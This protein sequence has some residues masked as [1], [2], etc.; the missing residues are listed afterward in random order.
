MQR[1]DFDPI[2]FLFGVVFLGL[3]V[4]FMTDQLAVLNHATWLWPVLLVLLGLAVLVGARG[5][6]GSRATRPALGSGSRIDPDLEDELLHSPMTTIDSERLEDSRSLFTLR[7]GSHPTEE[8]AA[9]PK[10]PEPKDPEPKEKA[11][12][13]AAEPKEA[14]TDVLP[15]ADADTEL[16]P[17]RDPRRE[18]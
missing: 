15:M 17:P 1:H 12:A 3:G 13:K 8:P 4:L 6:G 16:L 9:D 2:A 11:E 10:R 5:R 7:L 14:A 18:D